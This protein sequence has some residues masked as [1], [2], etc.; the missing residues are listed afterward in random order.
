MMSS[1]DI[2]TSKVLSKLNMTDGDITNIGLYGNYLNQIKTYKNFLLISHYNIQTKL[3]NQLTVLNLNTNEQK[4]I[5]F[6]HNLKQIQV[7]N[8]KLYAVDG[9]N[10]YIYNASNFK[11]INKFEI[12]TDKTNYRIS[13]FFFT[14]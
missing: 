12:R 11:L 14:K 3:G 8:D 1:N 10:M 13:S 7:K 9:N 2:A 6:I 5:P 4:I